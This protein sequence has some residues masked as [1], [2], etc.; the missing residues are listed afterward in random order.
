MAGRK[1]NRKNKPYQ[2]NIEKKRE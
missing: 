2:L 1:F